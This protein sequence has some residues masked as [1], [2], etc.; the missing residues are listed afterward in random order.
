MRVEDLLRAQARR[1][2]ARVVAVSDGRTMTYGALDESSNRL[3]NG[4][5]A[6]GLRGGDCVVAALPN[7]LELLVLMFATA[8]A[9]LVLVPIHPKSTAAETVYARERAAAKAT[10]SF[11]GGASLQ[12]GER[13]VAFDAFLASAPPCAL[14]CQ[15]DESA[16]WLLALTSGSTGKPKGVVIS[17]RAKYLSAVM[18]A[19]DLELTRSDVA[20]LNAPMFH[21]HGLVLALTL[22]AAGAQVVIDGTAF[23]AASLAAITRHGVTVLAMVPTMYRRMLDLPGFEPHQ[24]RTVRH[25]KCTGA[26]L[27]PALRDEL[28]A[29]IPGLPLCV[30]YGGT[31]AGPVTVLRPQEVRRKPG[32]VGQPLAGVDLEVRDASGHPLPPGETGQLFIRSDYVFSG[33][34]G[35]SGMPPFQRERDWITLGDIA[36]IDEDGF[37]FLQGRTSDVIISGGENI[38]AREVEEALERHA[39]VRTAAVVGIADPQWGERVI[40]FVEAKDGSEPSPD[41]ILAA[42][43]GTLARYK[44]PKAIDILPRLPLNPF[45][46]VDKQALRRIAATVHAPKE[47]P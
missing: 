39:A 24:L 40:A 7:C 31:E 15:G 44:L 14:A 37:L 42:A 16:P 22:V 17:H 8:K 2:P 38:S 19:L 33:Y 13:N 9:N 34:L 18:E 47:S 1:E 10:V 23:A 27:G 36:T 20:L 11:D 26:P 28:L 30:L 5:L 6:A 25:A 46:K 12:I 43:A 41:D 3:A 35:E 21:V 4:L 32:S 29:R 45:G